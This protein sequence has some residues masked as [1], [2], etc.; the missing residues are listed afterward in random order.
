MRDSDPMS[1]DLVIRPAREADLEAVGAICVAAYDA[2]GQLEP[3][4]PYASTLSDARARMED[5]LLLVAERDGVV[6]GTATITPPGSEFREIGRD[7][8][9]EFRFLAVAPSAWRTGVGNALVAACEQHAQQTGATAM[10]ICVRDTNTSAAA[11]YERMGFTR[12]PERD[13]TPRPGV[14]LLALTRPVPAP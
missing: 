12:I 14:D 3:G 13:W 2:A 11:M 10:A 8:E 1:S 9:V 5:G 4:S 7:D 6:V